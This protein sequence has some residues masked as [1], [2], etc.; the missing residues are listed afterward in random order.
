VR[1][2]FPKT[3]PAALWAG[4]DVEGGWWLAF[5]PPVAA[6]GVT[7]VRFTEKGIPDRC[8]RSAETV[9]IAAFSRDRIITVIEGDDGDALNPQRT[10][11]FP[12]K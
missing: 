4:T 10:V 6:G 9:R 5:H 1:G 11:P 3:R 8:Y 7:Y 2:W 12:S